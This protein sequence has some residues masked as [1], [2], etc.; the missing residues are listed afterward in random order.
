MDCVRADR[1]PVGAQVRRSVRSQRRFLA[2]DELVVTRALIAINVAV[3]V[4]TDVVK[5]V[6]PT[7]LGLFASAWTGSS[8]AGVAE[9]Q[10]WRLITAGFLHFGVLHLAMNMVALWNLGQSLEPQLGRMRFIGLYFV[11]L[12]GGSAGALVFAPNGLTGGASGAIFG[13]LGAL[14]VALR[15][16]GIPLMKT[17]IGPVLVLNLVLTLGLSG[18]SVGGHLGGLG[19]GAVLGW[20]LLRPRARTQADSTVGDLLAFVFLGAVAVGAALWIASNPLGGGNGIH[21]PGLRI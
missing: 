7:Q 12:L 21:L 11:S 2:V 4:L 13:L 17:S 10:W 20:V 19:T 5:S 8:V 3:F 1:E 9:G 18:I 6:A 15:A 14:A 16:R